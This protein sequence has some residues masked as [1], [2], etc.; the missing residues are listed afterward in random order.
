MTKSTYHY[1]F[2]NLAN[3]IKI[4]I[5]S[6]LNNKECSVNE[7]ANVLGIEQSKLSHALSSLRCCNI[8]TVKQ[9]G[10]QRVY[11]LNKETIIPMLNLIDRHEK[12]FCKACKIK[13]VK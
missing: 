13:V 5:I 3:P 7:L 1:F 8:V 2:K 6:Q 10:K 9:N 4:Q 12:T 11:S